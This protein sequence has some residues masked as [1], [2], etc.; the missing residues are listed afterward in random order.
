MPL[1]RCLLLGADGSLETQLV[2]TPVDGA[3]PVARAVLDK[4]TGYWG[5]ALPAITGLHIDRD[6][7]LKPEGSS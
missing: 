6:S 7:N 4:A 2:R 5:Y 1:R 3:V